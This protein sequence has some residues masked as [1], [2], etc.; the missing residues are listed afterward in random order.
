MGL[1]HM[2]ASKQIKLAAL[3]MSLGIALSS[4]T[5][6]MAQAK[7]SK[8][9][10]AAAA[11]SAKAG[12]QGDE[13][14]VKAQLTQFAKLLDSKDAKGLAALWTADGE[15]V[16][17]DGHQTK[18]RNELEERFAMVLSRDSK[19][20]IRL[21]SDTIKF[22]APSVAMVEGTVTREEEGQSRPTTHFSMVWVKGDGGWLLTNASERQV[23]ATSN[24]EFLR[25]FDWIIGEWAAKSSAATVHMKAEWVPSKNFILCK[26]DT[27]KNDGGH[28]VDMQIIGWDPILDVPRSWSFDSSGGYGQGFWSKSNNQWV[29]DAIAVESDASTTKARNV[30][31]VTGPDSFTW[32][33][34]N[35]SVDGMAVGDAPSLTVQ[36]I[37]K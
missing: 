17:E 21:L 1:E 6:Q 35:R 4:A 11:S 13:A 12:A 25:S 18:G 22:L 10:A 23:I 5:A 32:T 33:S 16:D 29:C 3:A 30:I 14:A 19:P 34:V 2:L 8:K 9:A 7:S 31:T 27:S 36:R 15:Y 28:S 20:N 24:Y 26:Y 37:G